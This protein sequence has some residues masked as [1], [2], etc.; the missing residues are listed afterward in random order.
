MD[1]N[2]GNELD[3]DEEYAESYLDNEFYMGEDPEH[4]PDFGEWMEVGDE[5]IWIS[6]ID[7]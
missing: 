2:F 1:E 4:N 7:Q 6:Y 5:E 3:L